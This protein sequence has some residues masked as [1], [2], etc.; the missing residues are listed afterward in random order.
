M[1]GLSGVVEDHPIVANHQV[2]R[3]KAL[4]VRAE[5][6]VMGSSRLA[7]LPGSNDICIVGLGVQDISLSSLMVVRAPRLDSLILSGVEAVVKS[8]VVKR[9]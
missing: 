2:I 3:P 5:V 7:G 4:S 6:A 1:P 8:K 9:L